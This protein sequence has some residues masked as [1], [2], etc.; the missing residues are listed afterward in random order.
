VTEAQLTSAGGTGNVQAN[1]GLT[2]TFSFSLANNQAVT[3][4]F[5]AINH[6]IAAVSAGEL[7]GSTARSTSGW[8]VDVRDQAG[9]LVFEW[10]PNGQAGGIVGGVENADTCDLNRTVNAQIPNQTSQFDCAGGVGNFSATTPVLLA[11]QLYTLGLRHTGATDVARRLPEPGSLL[12]LSTV[13]GGIG[14]VS[15]RRKAA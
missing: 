1:L 9:N 4:A 5:N 6:L 11:A 10:S 8:T 14:F 7:L 3:V 13:L 12:L 2:A 15:R